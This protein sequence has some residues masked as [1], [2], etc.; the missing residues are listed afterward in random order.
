MCAY[1]D[2]RT[3]SVGGYRYAVV[4]PFSS[5][6]NLDQGGPAAVERV[7]D[8]DDNSGGTDT[9]QRKLPHWITLGHSM[10]IYLGGTVTAPILS[11]SVPVD[12]NIPFQ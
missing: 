4:T 12:L 1:M 11:I 2:L 6:E 3:F 7:V 9:S 10:V 5:F 8:R